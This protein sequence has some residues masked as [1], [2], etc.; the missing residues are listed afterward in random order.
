MYAGGC[1]RWLFPGKTNRSIHHGPVGECT[2][3][4]CY[5]HLG[6]GGLQSITMAHM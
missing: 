2:W 5:T 1:G 4:A 3:Y 6:M